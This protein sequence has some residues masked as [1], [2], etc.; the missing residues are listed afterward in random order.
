MLMLGSPEYGFSGEAAGK[1]NVLLTE[2]DDESEFS[3]DEGKLEEI[4]QELYKEITAT[5][6]SSSPNTSPLMVTLPSPSSS[7][8]S[9]SPPLYLS[10]PPF[11]VSDVKSESCGASMS[12]S[13]S[14][15][16]AGIEFVV[17][18]GKLPEKEIGVTEMGFDDDNN[19]T[20]T[21]TTTT[22]TIYNNNSGDF[23][24]REEEMDGCDEGELG[25]DQW[26][27]IVLGWGPLELEDWT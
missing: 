7:S 12:D 8:S 5:T 2:S 26:L 21:T 19:T 27:T 3:N 11:S 4:M 6:T 22:T 16:M 18:A 14:T 1:L 9:S 17:P 23:V 24:A 25:N 20:T 10:P 13:S 15:V